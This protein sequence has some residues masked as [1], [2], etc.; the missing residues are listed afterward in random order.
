MPRQLA[1]MTWQ[2]FTCLIFISGPSFQEDQ[3]RQQRTFFCRGVA[4]CFVVSK[5]SFLHLPAK[6]VARHCTLFHRYMSRYH[7]E[8]QTTRHKWMFSKQCSFLLIK[9]PN[10]NIGTTWNNH[11]FLVV[12]VSR[13]ML[14]VWNTCIIDPVSIP[15]SH[16][17][18]KYASPISRLWIVF[19]IVFSLDFSTV[20]HGTCFSSFHMCA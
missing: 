8:T 7:L 17:I 14:H 5:G 18:G 15:P 13:Q 19:G 11:L 9:D 4:G 1:R 3:V 16:I 10:C 6:I 12:W 20:S 2:M